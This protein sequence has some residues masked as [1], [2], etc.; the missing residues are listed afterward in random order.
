[1]NEELKEVPCE[2]EIVSAVTVA[3]TR[4]IVADTVGCVNVYR[5]AW[6]PVKVTP[7]TE[8]DLLVPAAGLEKI[9]A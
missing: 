2:I 1:V 9:A 4:L 8:M 7:D 6:A 5:D 3:D